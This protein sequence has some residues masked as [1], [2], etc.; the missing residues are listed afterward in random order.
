[1][2]RTPTLG[3][4]ASTCTARA[5]AKPVTPE[6]EAEKRCSLNVKQKKNSSLKQRGKYGK[7]QNIRREFTM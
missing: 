1:M 2:R 5:L 3:N 6:T 4:L 7:L